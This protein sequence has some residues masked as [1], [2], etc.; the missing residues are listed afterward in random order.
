MTVV[1]AGITVSLDADAFWFVI[2]C[3]ASYYGF[4]LCQ[5][6]RMCVRDYEALLVAAQLATMES[7]G[8]LRIKYNAW[9]AFVDSG[10]FVSTEEQIDCDSNKTDLC[11]H[12]EGTSPI[13]KSN[14]TYRVF[15]IGQGQTQ[16][17]GIFWN[18]KTIHGCSWRCVYPEV[19]PSLT[20]VVKF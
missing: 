10:H 7:S 14:I 16:L 11:A 18:K 4:S 9:P 20:L 6:L 12:A 1:A 13:E 17:Q 5:H 8:M 19:N 2:N 15:C 3:D